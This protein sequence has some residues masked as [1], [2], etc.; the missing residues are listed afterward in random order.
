RSR[1]GQVRGQDAAAEGLRHH[2][3]SVGAT[4]FFGHPETAGHG[5][6]ERARARPLARLAEPVRAVRAAAALSALGAGASAAAATIDGFD[7][8]KQKGIYSFAAQARLAATRESIYAV[9]TDFDDNAY[10]RI[11]R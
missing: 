2:R 5:R 8:T 1:D 7:V 10:S 6:C 3:R 9:I 11:S 4:G